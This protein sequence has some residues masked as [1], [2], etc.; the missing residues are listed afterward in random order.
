MNSAGVELG[1]PS[2]NVISAIAPVKFTLAPSVTDAEAMPPVVVSG[3]SATLV[4]LMMIAVGAVGRVADRHRD[5][6]AAAAGLLGIGRPAGDA[7]L[8]DGPTPGTKRLPIR[9]IVPTDEVGVAVGPQLI[10]AES[11]PRGSAAGEGPHHR[12]GERHPLDRAGRECA[13]P[14]RVVNRQQAARLQTLEEDPR[15]IPTE[16][17]RRVEAD[18]STVRHA[19]TCRLF[20]TSTPW[21]LP[22]STRTRSWPRTRTAPRVGLRREQIVRRRTAPHHAEFTPRVVRR[23]P[24]GDWGAEA[25]DSQPDGTLG[26][27]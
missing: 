13:T 24:P 11:P 27:I 4:L 23:S 9:L 6:Q 1:L 8:G 16:P 14:D 5:R 26:N 21:S 17:P 7:V 12:A 3:A 25:E 10:V 19:P 20:I 2:V 22:W 15:A 18:R